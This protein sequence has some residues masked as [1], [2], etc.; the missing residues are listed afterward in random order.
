MSERRRFDD[1]VTK[2][3]EGC[4]VADIQGN[5]ESQLMGRKFRANTIRSALS[6]DSDLNSAVTSGLTKSS[7]EQLHG[8]FPFTVPQGGDVCG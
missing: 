6:S 2:A 8:N 5:K 4:E 1:F 7:K 3:E